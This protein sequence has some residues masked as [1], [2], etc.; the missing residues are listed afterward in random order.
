MFDVDM[1]ACKHCSPFQ[2]IK[3]RADVHGRFWA[4]TIPQ[5]TTDPRFN[6]VTVTPYARVQAADHQIGA[7]TK[8]RGGWLLSSQ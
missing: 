5:I 3:N 6:P 4:Q 2:L 1:Q 8:F 7:A